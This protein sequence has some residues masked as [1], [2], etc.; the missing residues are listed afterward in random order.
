MK[1]EE[2]KKL[3]KEDLIN[4]IFGYEGSKAIMNTLLINKNGQIRNF[5]IRLKKIRNEID[6]LLEHPYSVD[7]SYCNIPHDRDKMPRLSQFRHSKK[8]WKEEKNAN[9]KK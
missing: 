2:L 7:S 1:K 6:Y 8:R 4:K 3:S 9:R 5:R